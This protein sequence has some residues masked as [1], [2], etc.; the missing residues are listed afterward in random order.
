MKALDLTGER[1]G[2]L[3]IVSRAENSTRGNSRF[4]CRCD[5]GEQ[6]NVASGNLRNGTTKSC[7]CIRQ[8]MA[9]ERRFK[10]G[11]TKTAE[12]RAWTAMRNRCENPKAI[13]SAWNGR[14]ITVCER[15]QKFEN[16]LTD[17]GHRPSRTHS[18]D[19]IDV[20]GNYEPSNVRWATR[21]E[22]ANN[23]RKT[24]RINGEALSDVA[25]RVGL[26]HATLYARVAKYG[27]YLDEA[28]ALPKLKNQHDRKK[29]NV[30]RKPAS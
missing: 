27:F 22:Q 25:H 12:H 14:G 28:I 6:R 7:G 26:E 19:R 16:F 9:S 8:E 18:I 29:Q 15:W 24:I 4:N 30:A 23:T 17:V 10:H 5:C 20:N 11:K 13:Y 1:F 21:A 2:R 3:L